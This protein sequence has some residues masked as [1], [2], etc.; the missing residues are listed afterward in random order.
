MSY[1]NSYSLLFPVLLCFA[2]ACQQTT[3]E[4][5][6]LANQ[7]SEAKTARSDKQNEPDLAEFKKVDPSQDRVPASE[8]AKI[9][10]EAQAVTQP[11]KKDKVAVKKEPKKQI[12]K[13]PTKTVV[14]KPKIEFEEAVHSFG[15][16]IEGDII[17]HKF[18]FKNTGNAELVIKSAFASC[19]CTDPS[20]PF[21]GI[22]PGE[23]GYIG[24]TYNSVSKDGPQKPEVTIKTNVDKT[25]HVLYLTG[26]V[27]PK[28]KEKTSETKSDSTAIDSTKVKKN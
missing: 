20:Y 11:I 22:P 21:L 7:V 14:K 2:M 13:K 16:I 23:V 17:N 6:T 3:K 27:T 19:G 8:P 28:Q 18:K 26:N 4:S 5:T 9:K 1:S 24:V 10:A 15:D 25:A 12:A